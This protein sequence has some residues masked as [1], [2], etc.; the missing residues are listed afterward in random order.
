[1]EMRTRVK[2]G[3]LRSRHK[4][5]L[6]LG[7]IWRTV[8]HFHGWLAGL[9]GSQ[10]GVLGC[11]SAHFGSPGSPFLYFAFKPGGSAYLL[12]GLG[13]FLLNL[14]LLEFPRCASFLL[15]IK[16]KIGPRLTPKKPQ[17][18][19]RPAIMPQLELVGQIPE[20]SYSKCYIPEFDDIAPK[21]MDM[22]DL[23]ASCQITIDTYRTNMHIFTGAIVWVFPVLLTSIV[24]E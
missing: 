11:V 16:V 15:L 9:W 7:I 24:Q 10:H 2:R 18:N 4:L 1:M 13:V 5:G 14:G 8:M 22:M 6:S 21:I 23:A 17:N 20:T 12:E 19:S 3:K